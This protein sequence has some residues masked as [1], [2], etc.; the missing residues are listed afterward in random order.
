MIPALIYFVGI[1]IVF[2]IGMYHHKHCKIRKAS[3]NKLGN[4]FLAY[5][6]G[7]VLWPI[8]ILGVP[9]Y[10]LYVIV[11]KLMNMHIQHNYKKDD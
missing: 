3:Y 10:A 7:G 1:L 11:D 9:F 8:T 5:M 6:M 4:I 2:A